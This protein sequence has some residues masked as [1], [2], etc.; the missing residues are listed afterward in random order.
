MAD[1]TKPKKKLAVVTTEW[2]YHSHAW[3]M[4]ERFLAGYPIGG[5]W[6][7]PPFEVVT[8]YVDQFPDN[9]LSRGRAKE[10]GFK[11][12]PTIAEALRNGKDKLD[13][14]A[15]LII[16][17]HG[18]YDKSDI[19]QTKYPRYE[20][21]KAV[22]DVF[23]EDGKV[24]PI[25]NDK[26]LS[27]N[28]DWAKEM[29]DIARERNIPFL[30]GSSLAGHMADAVD[31]HALRRRGR[32][33]H[34][35]SRSAAS[36]ATTFTPWKPCNAWPNAAKGARRAS[37]AMQALRGDAVWEAMDAGPWKA[38]GW[39]PQLF[40]ACLTRTQTLAQPETYSHRYPTPEADPRMGQGAGRLP[41]RV[42]RRPQRDDAADERPGR[43]TSPS[44]PN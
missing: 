27:W 37:S 43:A 35:A 26:H 30:A 14:D 1:E 13:V 32:G 11:I 20:F 36:T 10:F 4:A 39:D 21:F 9:D 23:A 38:G 3:H 19:G 5:K 29:V 16:G 24:V 40:E 25:F 2:R 18:K 8:A 17:E 6:H 41:F 22:T 7:H 15:V 12:T 44:P 33:D 28:W 31:R 34:V 42:R